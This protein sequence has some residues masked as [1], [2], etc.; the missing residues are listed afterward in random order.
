MSSSEEPITVHGALLEVH[1]TGLLITGPSGIGKSELALELISR[2]HRYVADD[3][4]FLNLDSQSRLFGSC[5]DELAGFLEVR[6][7]GILNIQR[8]FGAAAVKSRQQIQLIIDLQSRKNLPPAEPD[9]RLAGRRASR[10]LLG[11]EIPTI[12]LP[13]VAGRN[14]AVLVETAAQDHQLRLNGYDASKD[15]IRVHG[16]LLGKL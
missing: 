1:S 3:S 2:G 6:G 10:T 7:L 11:V 8:L 5:P 12:T 15:L 13:V 4:P 14:F 16:Q 9:E